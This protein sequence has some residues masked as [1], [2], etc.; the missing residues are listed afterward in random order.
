MTMIDGLSDLVAAHGMSIV[1]KATFTLLVTLA[2]VHVARHSRASVRHLL[3]AAGF[4]VLLALP[5][6]VVL[7]PP[8]RVD[9]APMPVFARDYF[10]DAIFPAS[11]GPAREVPAVIVESG[12]EPWDL[13]ARELL[14][15][16]WLGG[17]VLFAT[18]VF[19]GLVQVRRLRQTALPWLAGHLVFGPLTF[20]SVLM[21]ALFSLGAHGIMTVNDIV[22][23]LA[24][25]FPEAI[26]NLR[27]GGK[28]KRPHDVDAG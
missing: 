22:Q 2:A 25:L 5:L 8:V 4:A 20:G 1:A 6:A 12:A 3:L 9:V 16:A 28:L 26:L 10:A 18:P 13:T 17:V 19:V 15:L 23:W 27:P 11:P 21:A 24:E 7:A 14:T